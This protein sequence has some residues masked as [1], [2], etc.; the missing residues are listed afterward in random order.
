MQLSTAVTRIDCSGAGG[1]GVLVV[2]RSGDADGAAAASG[3][4][5]PRA[6]TVLRAGKVVVSLPLGV[7]KAGAVACWRASVLAY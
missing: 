1:D 4:G 2:V 5:S 6:G 3:G 7:L